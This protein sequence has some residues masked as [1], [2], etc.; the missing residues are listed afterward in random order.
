MSSPRARQCNPKSQCQRS[1]PPC[2][3][4]HPFH[5]RHPAR[6]PFHYCHLSPTYSRF[7]MRRLQRARRSR[8]RHRP[9]RPSHRQSLRSQPPPQC[10]LCRQRLLQRH[11]CR[12]APLRRRRPCPRKTESRRRR[13]CTRRCSGSESTRAPSSERWRK[14]VRGAQTIVSANYEPAANTARSAASLTP[15]RR[16]CSA[17]PEAP[18]QHWNCA[19]FRPGESR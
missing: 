11:R 7:Q 15:M 10:L 19:S 16:N 14:R 8:H 13:R 6:L 3:C 2:R 12:P 1:R 18:A 5:I 4:T 9:Y 17:I